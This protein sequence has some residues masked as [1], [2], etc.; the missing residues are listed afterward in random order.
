M[1]RLVHVLVIAVIIASVIA[2][3]LFYQLATLQRLNDELRSQNSEFEN[4]NGELE[5]QIAQFSN[6]V[7]ITDFSI[8]GLKPDEKF[9]I[10]ESTVH[11]K[12]C[13]FGIND[14]ENLTLRIVG[15]GDERLAESLQVGTLHVGEEKEIQANAYWGY[16]SHGTS[17]ATLMLGDVVLDEYLL[18]FSEMYPT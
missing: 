3:F 1:R 14:V 17:I 16:G 9:I 13:N 4:K 7:N 12:I 11:V 15:F 18:T 10:W 6:K 5:N 2:G 8:S